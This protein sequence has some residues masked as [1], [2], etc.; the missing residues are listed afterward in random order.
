MAK[1][2]HII[3]KTH[4]VRYRRITDQLWPLVVALVVLGG[5]LAGSVL[6]YLRLDDPRWFA[7]AWTWLIVIVLV[8]STALAVLAWTGNRLLRRTMQLS[9]VLGVIVHVVLFI[10]SLETDVFQRAWVE[11][12]AATERPPQPRTVKPPAV[13][14]WR[15]APERQP[16]HDFEQPVTVQTPEPELA[17]ARAA[18]QQPDP[19]TIDMP[20]RP[21]PDPQDVPL[22]SVVNR[23]EPNQTVPRQRD[24]MSVL[25]RRH[26]PLPNRPTQLADIPA[27]VPRPERREDVVQAEVMGLEPETDVAEQPRR[28]AQQPAMMPSPAPDLQL[29]R[30]QQSAQP[31]P[32]PSA[33]AA[34]VPRADRTRSVTPESAAIA[35]SQ[36]E[37][38][39]SQAAAT[40]EPRATDVDDKLL[41]QAPEARRRVDPPP[42]HPVT[43]STSRR[44]D[45]EQPS[46]AR[47]TLAQTPRAASNRQARVTTR[48]DLTASVERVS[49]PSTTPPPA[50]EV[51][52][53]PTA[54]TQPT[55]RT[56]D[57]QMAAVVQGP[58]PVAPDAA[59]RDPA[60][61][62]RVR[63]SPADTQRP[64]DPVSATL[65]GRQPADAAALGA[66]AE[67]V[68]PVAAESGA[69]EP[70]RTLAG[71][72]ASAHIDVA[73]QAAGNGT[74][75]RQRAPAETIG[76][77]AVDQTPLVQPRRPSAT[78]APSLT[79]VPD[80]NPHPRRALRDAPDAVS[81]LAAETPSRPAS[82]AEQA[83]TATEP[84]VMALSKAELGTAGR[85]MSHNLGQADPAGT[86][87]GAVASGSARRAQATQNLPAGPALEPHDAAIVR[88]GRAGQP[89][90]SAVL[91]PIQLSPELRAG[92]RQPADIQASAS[93]ALA[94]AASDAQRGSITAAKGNLDVDTGPTTLVTETGSGRGAGGGQP[95]LSFG[96]QR[97]TVPRAQSGHAPLPSLLAETPGTTVTAPS[98]DGGGL[99]AAADVDVNAHALLDARPGPQP[100]SIGGPQAV[101][102]GPADVPTV[103]PHDALRRAHGLLDEFALQ[104]DS[105]HAPHIA[106]RSDADRQLPVDAGVADLSAGNAAEQSDDHLPST[107][108]ASSDTA[109]TAAERTAPD[110]GGP[111]DRTADPSAGAHAANP[112][113]V[114]PASLA[115]RAEAVQ[116]ATGQPAVGGGTG[117]PPRTGRG[118]AVWADTL[119]DTVD[120]AG[121][122]TAHGQ[123]DPQASDLPHSEARRLATNAPAASRRDRPGGG[124]A[125]P[126]SVAAVDTLPSASPTRHAG[127]NS[128]ADGP[129]VRDATQRGGPGKRS[130]QLQLP[131]DATTVDL[132]DVVSPSDVAGRLSTDVTPALGGPRSGPV[133]RSA[134]QPLP[135]N[136]DVPTGLGGLG[137]TATVDVGLAARRTAE[138]NTDIQID[139]SRFNRN[140][141][142]GQPRLNVTAAMPTE[143]FQRRIERAQGR[144]DPTGGVGP[145]TE[146]AIELGLVFLSKAQLPDGRWS[147]DRFARQDGLPQLAS[148]AAATGLALLAFQGAGYNHIEFRYADV[149]RRGVEFLLQNQ[150]PDG[151]LFIP[152]DDESNRV[153]QFYSHSIAALAVCEAYGMTQD[154]ML[155]EPAQRAIDFIVETQNVQRGGWRYTRGVSSDTSVSGWM[156]M[157][158]KS[159]ELA[160]LKVPKETYAAIDRWLDRAQ[161]SS[162]QPH[163]YCYNPFA[164]DTPEQRAGRKPTATMTSVGLLMRMYLGWR[165][166]NPAL[167]RGATYLSRIPPAIGTRVDPKRDTYYWYYGTQVMFHMGGKFWQDW[168]QALH[169]LLVETQ[170]R[171]GELAGSWDPHQPVPDR[172]AAHAGRL[173]VTTMNLLSLEVT[174]RHLPLYED[175]AK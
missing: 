117:S 169:P 124:P 30:R 173:Y 1:T 158:L 89:Q 170:I 51:Q 42:R 80:T 65:P 22:P 98:S 126:L 171:Q 138:P 146:D 122:P 108:L 69:V 37:T 137:N 164:P 166:N 84:A 163:L 6:A 88:S 106:P 73:R 16:R 82:A 29:A 48:P 76:S 159:G 38:P 150:Q 25:S 113:D 56:K 36:P 33:P 2:R 53:L 162:T 94:Q 136:I 148:D 143:S 156:T 96:T 85:G 115:A 161:A 8:I 165:R 10:A 20:A 119:A 68:S 127:Q 44:R 130:A 101:G 112:A 79:A 14:A 46:P 34:A 99:P 151:S 31:S 83:A 97:S 109:V 157:A 78:P 168:H 131:S 102:G 19:T 45:V 128:A 120:I 49:A 21:V 86:S 66:L 26:S 144:S 17:T 4:P 95:D 40:P 140:R 93:A 141:V 107:T 90:P 24:D 129:L 70:S 39:P 160:N 174:Y 11:M 77:V 67:R 172:W 100:D 64:T 118:P 72:A 87:P 116:A 7:N 104:D 132:A 154:P 35:R 28:P 52:P 114:G 32:E 60:A 62:G 167:A 142:G 47:N 9:I 110:A 5:F 92:A 61:A 57:Q 15:P 139:S 103:S 27:V 111:I 13:T 81:P 43:E 54:P 175:T 155:R 135:V 125:M 50:T 41:T 134:G 133:S 121:T 71:P 105:H 152:M 3:R 147:L 153:V 12:V 23:A 55:Q 59:D 58:Q 18:P 149:V 75:E 74:A 145:Q 63:R 91:A 123:A